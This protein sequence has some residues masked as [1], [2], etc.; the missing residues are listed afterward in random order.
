MTKRIGEL[1]VIESESDQECSR[2]RQQHECRDVL[3]NGQPLCFH[4]A[5][6]EEKETYAQRL[7]GGAKAT[8]LS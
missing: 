7:F 3:G 4:C 8:V 1:V 5:T 2:C 6:P